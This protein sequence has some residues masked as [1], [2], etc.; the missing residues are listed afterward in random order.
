MLVMSPP[1]HNNMVLR[2]APHCSLFWRDF[3]FGKWV[4]EAWHAISDDELRFAMRKVISPHGLKLSQLED[5]PALAHTISTS[6]S[7]PEC[8]QADESSEVRNSQSELVPLSWS[9]SE[10]ASG[11]AFAAWCSGK[12]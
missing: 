12:S 3:Q 6:S 1:T 8:E 7:S 4:S 10:S 2:T 5:V 9:E 11:F